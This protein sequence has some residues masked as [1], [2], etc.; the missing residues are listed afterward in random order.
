MDDSRGRT[1][2]RVHEKR[3]QEKR[4]HEMRIAVQAPASGFRP[5][6][7]AEVL[8]GVLADWQAA[9]L[10][11]DD[12][13]LWL[14]SG[15][16]EEQV[17]TGEYARKAHSLVQAVLGTGTV[18]RAEADLP[19]TA[20]VD[21]ARNR[22]AASDAPG[23]PPGSEVSRWARDA[24][25]CDE[26]W[27]IEPTRGDGIRIGHPDTG[28][29]LHPN[30]GVDALDL[31]RDR[32]FLANDDDARDP[33]VSPD[34]SPWPLPFPGHGTTTASVMTGQ[35][36]E[37]TGI[38]GVAPG[39]RV[40]PLRA[41]ESVIQLFDSDVARAV[42]HA[43]TT[44]CHVV[45]ISIGGKGFFGLEAAIQRAVDAGMIVLGAAGN[46]VGIVV[47]PASYPNCLAVAATGPDDQP[48]PES[49][50][51]RA[52][53]VSAPGWG[54]H[55]AGYVWVNDTPR[56]RVFRSSGTSYAA[57]HLAGVAALWLAHHGPDTLRERYGPRVQSVFLTLLKAGGARVP[58]GWDATEFGAGIVDAAAMLT[59]TLPAESADRRAS[60]PQTSALARLGALVGED[61]A[62]LRH[63][64]AQWLGASGENVDRTVERFE[65]E[66]AFHLIEEPSFRE[67][68]LGGSAGAVV[69]SDAPASCS[70]EFALTFL[71]PAPDVDTGPDGQG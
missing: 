62:Q 10:L 65:G 1:R 9:P 47:A 20:F 14:I 51:G 17:G 49:S 50:R 3:V 64:L 39:A 24:I 59:A 70:R 28:Y 34:D 15:H 19:V 61:Q 32:D 45:S 68:L 38:V 52:V 12:D 21:P 6:D 37:A 54:V 33:L 8:C 46:N 41:V 60:V 53:D 13:T 11:E 31:T 67:A 4:V 2:S 26:A 27:A 23:F 48:W 42:D 30:L 7:L 55:V 5:D 69:S 22:G 71:N 57:T 16:V 56:A 63:A 36:T 25:R 18:T 44:G 58:A 66:L 35:G 40:V 43:R 29:T